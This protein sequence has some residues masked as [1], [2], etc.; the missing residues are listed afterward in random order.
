MQYNG[1]YSNH[2]YESPHKVVERGAKTFTVDVNRQAGDTCTV[3]SLDHL[4]PAHI[5]DSATINIRATDD[6]PLS[7][8]AVP[9]PPPTMRTTWSERHVR[10]PDRYIP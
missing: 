5:E 2:I 1:L 7:P 6:I 10:W 4:K 3:V 8:S 9:T